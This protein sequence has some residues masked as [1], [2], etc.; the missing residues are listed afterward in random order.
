M[1]KRGKVF[2]SID[3]F[4]LHPHN[5]PPFLSSS[6]YT[7]Y[8]YDKA[9]HAA[10]VGLATPKAAKLTP[11]GRETAVQPVLPDGASAARSTGSASAQAAEDEA[12]ADNNNANDNNNTE[13]GIRIGPITLTPRGVRIGPV[14]GASADAATAPKPSSNNP[15]APVSRKEAKTKR[16]SMSDA[17]AAGAKTATSI[18]DEASG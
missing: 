9:S 2:F 1:G 8:K 7:I 4:F 17:A 18:G 14:G 12:P 5:P 10:S 3:R 15:A 13:R 16:T 11:K 6:R